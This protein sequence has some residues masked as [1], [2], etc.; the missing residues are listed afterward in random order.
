[1]KP[2]EC[3]A[4]KSIV[5]LVWLNW[6]NIY[7]VKVAAADR[8]RFSAVTKKWPCRNS[9]KSRTIWGYYHVIYFELSASVRQSLLI[10]IYFF[11]CVLCCVNVVLMLCWCWCCVDVGV[12]WCCIYWVVSLASS[13]VRGRGVCDN[14]FMRGFAFFGVVPSSLHSVVSSP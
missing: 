4:F 2:N 13:C 10:C 1:M 6:I 9:H 14:L 12:C 11:L 8:S 7:Y 5:F 3:Q